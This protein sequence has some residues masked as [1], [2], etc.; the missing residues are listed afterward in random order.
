MKTIAFFS[1]VSGAGTTSLVYHVAWMFADQG[2]PVLAV[3]LDP[4]GDLTAMLLGQDRRAELGLLNMAHGVILPATRGEIA[5][6]PLEKISETL[7]VLPCDLDLGAFEDVLAEAFQQS[8]KASLE[9]ITTIDRLIKDKA[10]DWAKLVLIDL[11]PNLGALNRAALTAADHIILPVAPTIP[12]RQGWRTLGPMLSKWRNRWERIPKEPTTPLGLMKPAGY[13]V[14]QSGRPGGGKTIPLAYRQD[15]LSEV[16]NAAPGVNIEGDPN[17]L[18]QLKHYV[19]MLHLAL[20]AHKPMFHLT[21]VDGAIGAYVEAVRDC[22]SEYLALAR[23][24]AA[25]AGISL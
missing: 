2:L 11:G 25:V 5:V 3:D 12:F 17:C 9:R 21:P 16:G 18:G 1:N 20:E 7:G 15:V 14:M 13:I 22:K 10:G 4:Q 23:R 6:P 8:D 19:G 24:I